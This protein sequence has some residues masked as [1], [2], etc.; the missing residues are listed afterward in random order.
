MGTLFSQS[1]RIY[2]EV[3]YKDLQSETEELLSLAKEYSITLDQAI[4]IRR[5]LEIRRT[6]QLYINDRDTWDEQIAGIGEILQRVAT[7]LDDFFNR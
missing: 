7:N 3:D 4:A 5:V 6:N 2:H 1:P